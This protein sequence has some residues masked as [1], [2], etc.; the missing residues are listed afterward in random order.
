MCDANETKWWW[1][2]WIRW[3]WKSSCFF[4]FFVRCR[5]NSNYAKRF[6]LTKSRFSRLSRCQVVKSTFAIF[7]NRRFVRLFA[8]ILKQKTVFSRNSS[9]T[10]ESNLILHSNLFCPCVERKQKSQI[11]NAGQH[12]IISHQRFTAW[13]DQQIGINKFVGQVFQIVRNFVW[14][15]LSEKYWTKAWIHRLIQVRVATCRF[16]WR[17]K[18]NQT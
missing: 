5:P 10:I 12:K 2:G 3:R 8:D 13:F 17:K 1:I 4:L 9:V 15:L 6:Y 14:E 18:E 7:F 16:Y 11:Q